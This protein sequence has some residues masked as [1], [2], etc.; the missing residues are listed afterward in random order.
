MGDF[1]SQLSVGSGRAAKKPF[2]QAPFSH[3]IEDYLFVQAP[4]PTACDECTKV[5]C[6]KPSLLALS[7]RNSLN[8]L[9]GESFLADNLI[10]T[11]SVVCC[12]SGQLYSCGRYQQ[13]ENN[14]RMNKATGLQII[15]FAEKNTRESHRFEVQSYEYHHFLTI[16][17]LFLQSYI[18]TWRQ[19]IYGT[20]H[21]MYCCVINQP[22]LTG[23]WHMSLYVCLSTSSLRRCTNFYICLCF[24]QHIKDVST[25]LRY[26]TCMNIV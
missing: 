21:W 20:S 19:V 12:L 2:E 14:R 16:Y 18:L 15:R 4:H 3:N 7:T 13:D 5:H 1:T 9:L 24:L 25:F 10:P 8:K 11:I 6:C 26:G 17:C 22:N 23:M